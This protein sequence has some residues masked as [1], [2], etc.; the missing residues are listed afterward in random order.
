MLADL[1]SVLYGSGPTIP[2]ADVMVLA[3][4]DTP[5]NVMAQLREAG[6]TVR[7]L[8]EIERRAGSRPAR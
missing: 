7:T 3:A 1:P 4:A 5:A 8:E 2:G 6:G